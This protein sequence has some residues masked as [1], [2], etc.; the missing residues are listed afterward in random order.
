MPPA[1]RNIEQVSRAKIDFERTR[2][3]RERIFDKLIRI[4]QISHLAENVLAIV[5]I[6]RLARRRQDQLL[7]PDNLGQKIVGKVEVKGGERPARADPGHSFTGGELLVE[8]AEILLEWGQ[9]RTIGATII[10]SD[11]G[12][13][14]KALGG[15]H[16]DKLVEGHRPAMIVLV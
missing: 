11:I 2:T 12:V 16:V 14:G 10:G 8:L 6:F 13:V 7:V 5:E 4:G 15:Y 9:S 1:D 3:L